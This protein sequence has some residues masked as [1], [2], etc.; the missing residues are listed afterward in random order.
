MIMST[1]LNSTQLI[2]QAREPARA[3]LSDA[4]QN[5][6]GSD[7]KA[8][9]SFDTEGAAESYIQTI[10]MKADLSAAMLFKTPDGKF[11]VYIQ[12][13]EINDENRGTAENSVT[14]DVSNSAR[15][16][17]RL[18]YF[19]EGSLFLRSYIVY[20]NNDNKYRPRIIDNYPI[21]PIE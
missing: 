14:N 6:F 4:F 1:Q 21:A 5:M 9:G 19:P 12:T 10:S 20:N 3:G 8:F 13:S 2:A 7:P 15:T 16:G 18:G 17:Y 11:I